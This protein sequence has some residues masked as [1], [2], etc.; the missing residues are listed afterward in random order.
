MSESGRN[1]AM[2]RY[3]QDGKQKEKAFIREC[4]IDWSKAPNRYASKAA[5]ARDMLTKVEKITSAKKIEDWC[6]EWEKAKI[7]T[8]HA[9]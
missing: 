3:S 8:V 4:W 2:V 1:A 9:G 5:F 7:L 6:R